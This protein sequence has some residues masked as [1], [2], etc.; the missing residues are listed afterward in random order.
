M[1]PFPASA[2]DCGASGALV[3]AHP[4]SSLRICDLR[5]WLRLP[6]LRRRCRPGV[7]CQELGVLGI[8]SMSR[9]WGLRTL[10]R[11]CAISNPVCPA[12]R[13]DPDVPCHQMSEDS[14]APMMM[15]TLCPKGSFA[16]P[17]VTPPPPLV[18]SCLRTHGSAV[19]CGKSVIVI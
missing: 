14:P 9:L 10:R 19:A 11:P 17:A 8:E 3:V 16:V 18:L 15:M 1:N 2:C 5:D 6:R 13:S 12:P 7:D 4:C